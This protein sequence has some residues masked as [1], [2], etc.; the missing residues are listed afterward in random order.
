[1]LMIIF[2]KVQDWGSSCPE[3]FFVSCWGPK[4]A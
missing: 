1:M 2:D 4:E 3:L